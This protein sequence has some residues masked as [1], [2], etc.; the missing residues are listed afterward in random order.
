MAIKKSVTIAS[1]VAVAGTTASI[2]HASTATTMAI[3]STAGATAGSGTM[4]FK[5]VGA[6]LGGK[7][8]VGALCI[9][10]TLFVAGLVY[11]HLESKS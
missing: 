4:V 1:A 5:T 9:G 10:A 6:T 7:V 11:T 3:T 8:L 2:W